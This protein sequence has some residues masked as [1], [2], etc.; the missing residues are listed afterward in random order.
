MSPDA[1]EAIREE[2]YQALKPL[3]FPE[4]PVQHDIVNLF[5]SL[6]RVV[7]MEDRGWDPLLESRA[8]LEDLNSIMQMELSEEDFPDPE[9][10]KWRMGLLMYSHMV[11]MDA[12]Y[13]M[14]ANLLRFGLGYGYSPNPFYQFLNSDERKRFARQGIFPS[15]KIKIIKKLAKEASLSIG[16]VFD[17]L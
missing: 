6:L 1:V 10:T 4:L 12:P 15:G 9:M 17:S 7:G 5:A 3:F 2:Y 11:E 14:I 16:D 8:T 13:E